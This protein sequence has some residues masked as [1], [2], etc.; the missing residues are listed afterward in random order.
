MPTS[1][2]IVV[3]PWERTQQ[4]GPNNVTCCWSTTLRPFAES[5]K[6]FAQNIIYSFLKD[7]GI[8]FV[9]TSLHVMSPLSAIPVFGTVKLLNNRVASDL[10]LRF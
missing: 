6:D 2:N 3:V 9:A 10:L 5:F 8:K 7:N 1:A 4:V